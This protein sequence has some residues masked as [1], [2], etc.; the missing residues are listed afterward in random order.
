MT[1]S[2]LITLLTLFFG[3]QLRAAEISGRVTDTNGEALPGVNVYIQDSYDGATTDLDGA[4]SFRTAES[5]EI[6]LIAS[7][8]G[9][10]TYQSLVQLRGN[11][12]I[13]IQLKEEIS[14]LSGVTISASSFEASDEK[15]STILKPLDIAMT[16]GAVADIPTALNMLPGTTTN[17]E[18][19]RLFVRGGTA[20]ETQAFIDG[21]W[22]NNFYSTRP[23][24]VPSRSRFD[25]FLF[26]GTFFSTGGYSAEYGQALSSIVSLNSQDL[27]E[28]TLTDIG[29]MT[30]GGDVAHTQRWEEASLYGKLQ[31]SNLDPYMNLVDQQ[32]DWVD[33]STSVNGT[34]MYRQR[35]KGAD[36]LKVYAS[37]DHSAFHAVM[38]SINNPDGDEVASN[39]Q[40]AYI[41]A[42]YKKSIGDHSMAYAGISYGK[43]D[44]TTDFNT[45]EIVQSTESIHGKSYL[46]TDINQLSVKV[47]GE[48]IYYD[49]NEDTQVSEIE[50]YQTQFDNAMAVGF[51]ELDYY[52]TNELT[53]RAGLR[54][55]HYSNFDLSKW[56]PRVS[57]AYKTG[58]YSQ[59]SAAFGKFHQLPNNDL[60]L[61]GQDFVMPEEADHYILSYQR[62]TKGFTLRSE[63]YYKNYDQLITYSDPYNP[64]TY[65]NS[66]DGYA[67]G[68]DLFFRDNQTIKNADYW[69]SYS[70]I[71]SKRKFENYPES[72][73]STF[74]AMH[75]V[76]VVYK[77]FIPVLRTQ[78]GASWDFNNGRPYNDP[79]K[80]DFNGERTKFYS[81]LS[82]N[83]AFLCKQNIIIYASASNLL[84]RDNVF[85]YEFANQA[86]ADGMMASRP[87]GQQAKRFF[88]VGLFISLS[89]DKQYN[90]LDNL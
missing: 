53:L 88:F 82:F 37:Y 16:A 26:K 60:M 11:V 78:I 87:I 40:N 15:K 61:I 67:R 51:T 81:D 4:F 44:E 35:I 52:L 71:D 34:M 18:T 32:Y 80:A 69:I 41:N 63:L 28:E 39:N 9:F 19:G 36:M 86:G 13:D 84:G 24:N 46:S 64:T 75:N 10:K 2:T 73:R 6:T 48:L 89:K 22:I 27:A 83:F 23:S 77:H 1:R 85:G 42:T 79:N 76:S 56:S 21:V 59:L 20:N 50:E 5:G 43:Y 74:T 30:I 49:V 29:L 17:A 7:S 45:I 58:E 57:M 70:F 14:R 90:Q 54:Y 68:L 66:G 38:P 65:T 55:S 72:A 62:I 47:G 3:F 8:I 31:Y 25:P 12:K 33:G